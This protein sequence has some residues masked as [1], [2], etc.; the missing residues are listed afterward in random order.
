MAAV[1]C[2]EE[3]GDQYRTR[4]TGS[5]FRYWWMRA[6]RLEEPNDEGMV[7]YDQATFEARFA[8]LRRQSEETLSGLQAIAAEQE[9]LAAAC[10]WLVSE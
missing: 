1:R 7:G 10:R 8:A 3:F 9:H 5:T 6:R 2:E 4:L